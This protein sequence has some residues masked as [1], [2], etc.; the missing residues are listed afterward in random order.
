MAGRRQ[1]LE[2]TLVGLVQLNEDVTLYLQGG[3]TQGCCMGK[4]AD[5][6]GGS[7]PRHLLPG[8]GTSLLSLNLLILKKK[9]K[10]PEL[11]EKRGEV[12]EE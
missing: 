2:E 12:N 9:K 7:G 8:Q 3:Q 1:A 11:K 4:S 10:N 5:R 6:D